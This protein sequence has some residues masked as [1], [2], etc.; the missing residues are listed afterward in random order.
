MVSVGTG[1]G[2]TVH[3]K[4]ILSFKKKSF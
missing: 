2:R 1:D 4:T 3:R